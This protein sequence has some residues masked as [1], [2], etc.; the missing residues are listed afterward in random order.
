MMNSHVTLGIIV[1]GFVM[2]LAGAY[3]GGNAY[4]PTGAILLMGGLILRA[5]AEIA[6]GLDEICSRM[7][8]RRRKQ[9]KGD[10]SGPTAEQQGQ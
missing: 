6:F 4:L 3:G 8:R 9:G 2:M 10:S 1:V 7:R 5:F